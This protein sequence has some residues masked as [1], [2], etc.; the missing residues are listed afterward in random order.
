MTESWPEVVYFGWRG[1]PPFVAL[2]PGM[3]GAL[4]RSNDEL[5]TDFRDRAEATSE[6]IRQQYLKVGRSLMNRDPLR[7]V[8][9]QIAMEGR[10]ILG[11][12]V[13]SQ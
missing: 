5:E 6:S 3:V 11:D 9:D 4:S 1:D 7:T 10:T 12:R 2:V 8:L 13:N